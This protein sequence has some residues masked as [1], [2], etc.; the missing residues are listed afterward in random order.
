[1]PLPR[2]GLVERT[3]L[4]GRLSRERSGRVVSVVA[5]PGYGKTTVLAQWA[6]HDRRDFAWLSLDHRDNDPVVF[7]TYVAEA[8]NADST[9]DPAVFKAL[10]SPGDSPWSR[11]LPRLV[12]ALAARPEPLVLVLDDVHELE[13]HDCLDAI[14]ALLLHVPR[15]SQL[16]LSGRTEARQG[17]RSFVPTASCSSW[18]Q[19]LSP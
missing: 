9:V 7:L 14:A 11:A 17:S 16:V 15:G 1:V 18:G 3:G 5:P 12:A 6:A 19:R 4:V 13:N 2:P 10:N 8:L